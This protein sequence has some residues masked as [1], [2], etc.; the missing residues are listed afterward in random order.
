MKTKEEKKKGRRKGAGKKR[1]NA[2]MFL[3]HRYD[4]N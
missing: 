4:P 1:E 2:F 3:S